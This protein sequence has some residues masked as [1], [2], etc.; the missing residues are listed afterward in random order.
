M[1]IIQF[2]HMIKKNRS[3]PQLIIKKISLKLSIYIYTLKRKNHDY[4]IIPFLLKSLNL[5]IPT[6]K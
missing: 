1:S 3:E 6:D 4:M 5:V 2:E